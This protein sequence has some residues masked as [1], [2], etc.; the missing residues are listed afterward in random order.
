MASG[1][2][3]TSLGINRLLATNYRLPSYRLKFLLA[4]VELVAKAREDG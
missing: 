1:Y 2:P 3:S 4:L